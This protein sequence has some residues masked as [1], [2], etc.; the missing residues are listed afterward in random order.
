MFVIQP[1]SIFVKSPN[2]NYIQFSKKENI[3]MI[4]KLENIFHINSD[5]CRIFHL[6]PYHPE[7][8]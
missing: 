8:A 1:V 7:C 2:C 5:V 3:L 6:R 4:W